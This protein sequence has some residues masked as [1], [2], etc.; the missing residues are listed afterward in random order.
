MKPALVPIPAGSVTL[1]DRRTSRRWDVSVAA[2]EIGV[3][4]V[5]RQEYA[6]GLG[7]QAPP[8]A[9]WLAANER[10]VPDGLV[11][12]TDISWFDAVAHCN[13]LSASAGLTPAYE[14]RSGPTDVRSLDNGSAPSVTS[15]APSVP[16][17]EVVWDRAADGYRLPTEAEWEHACRAGTTGPRYG[18]L[19]TIAWF[20]D[21][22]DERPHEVGLKAP[23]AF[24]L[25]DTLGNVWEWCWDVYDAE[26]Y[27]SYRVLRGGGWFDEHWS[28]R[29]SVRRRSHPTLRLDDVGLRVARG[30]RGA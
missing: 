30:R 13:R 24:G 18:D 4:P 16:E 3:H 17:P 9:G 2:F 27:G 29:A 10:P 28:C 6:E 14:I 19:D 23:N 7:E 20:R 8:G 12:A 26:A 5:T 22:S 11:P 1:S 25:H 15:S 21:N